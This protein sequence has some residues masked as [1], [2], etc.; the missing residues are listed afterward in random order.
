MGNKNVKPKDGKQS[1]YEE[2]ETR[3]KDAI[4]QKSYERI[5]DFEKERKEKIKYD[6]NIILYSNEIFKDNFKEMLNKIK[7]EEWKITIVKEGFSEENSEYIIQHLQ[8]DY[9]ELKFK[10]VII[11]PIISLESFKENLKDDSKNIFNHFSDLEIDEQPFIVFLDFNDND[12]EY[13][14]YDLE[15]CFLEKHNY[16]NNEISIDKEDYSI[17]KSIL[18]HNPLEKLKNIYYEKLITDEQFELI[19]KFPIKKSEEKKIESLIDIIKRKKCNRD[20]FEIKINNNTLYKIFNDKENIESN[21]ALKFFNRENIIDCFEVT[22]ISYNNN[23]NFLKDLNDYQNFEISENNIKFGI[24]KFAKEEIVNNDFLNKYPDLDERNIILL[25]YNKLLLKNMLFKI[26]GYYNQ[27]GDIIIKNKMNLYPVKINI[28]VCGPSGSG[29]STLINTLLREKRCLEGQGKSQTNYISQY[30]SLD[31]PIT[32]YD[33]PGFGDKDN[34]E[35][36]IKMIKEKNAQLKQTQESIHIVLYCIKYHQRTFLDKEPDVIKELL[37]LNVKIIFVIT[38]S[39]SPDQRNFISF[40]KTIINEINNIIKE[41]KISPQIV[42]KALG[43]NFENIIIPVY[44]RKER[45]QGYSFKTFGMDVLFN[46]IFNFLSPNLINIQKLKEEKDIQTIIDSNF[47]LQ[48]FESEEKMIKS[49]NNKLSMNLLLAFYKLFLIVPKIIYMTKIK[50]VFE[51]IFINSILEPIFYISEIYLVKIDITEAI[52]YL[53][54]TILPHFKSFEKFNLDIKNDLKKE[55]NGLY[56]ISIW[57]ARF[58]FPILSPLYFVSI[59]FMPVAAIIIKK[60]ILDFF[61]GLDS[62]KYLIRIAE[63][64]NL[65]ING[66]KII[67]DYYKNKYI[68]ENS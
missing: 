46:I 24:Y 51:D 1:K 60:I 59:L 48:T 44:C 43:D 20:D 18:A 9:K 3:F 6:L 61:K 21:E 26:C 25:R 55:E 47:F 40:R 27:F 67:S 65:G 53:K 13:L 45:F 68:N 17:Y 63:G 58:L 54:D 29:K 16:Y 2:I 64:L 31:F 39:D 10:N 4:D 35:K 62:K 37:N 22:I 30:T 14:K 12:F 36:L 28:A 41:K 49:L 52:L 66:L 57:I 19:M 11:I 23:I 15:Q 5:I 56:K 38:R 34:A 50:D 33:F 7:K 42:Q 8:K 32:Y